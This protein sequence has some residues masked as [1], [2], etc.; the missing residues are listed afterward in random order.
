AP[1][2]TL[3]PYTTL[4]RSIMTIGQ[5][6]R[7]SLEHHD[8]IRFVTPEQFAVYERWG[9]DAGFRYVASGPYVRSSYFAEEVLA[10]AVKLDG[11]APRSEEH[12][13]ELQSLR[14]L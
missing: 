12:T 10:G 3:S 14:H 7:P 6:L 13:S 4:F 1:S 9:R 2:P 8:I 5:Y 11:L